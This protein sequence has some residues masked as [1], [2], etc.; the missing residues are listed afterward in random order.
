MN[1]LHSKEVKNT[2]GSVTIGINLN[3]EDYPYSIL[4]GRL[5]TQLFNI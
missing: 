3:K 5:D 4:A 1:I 2:K